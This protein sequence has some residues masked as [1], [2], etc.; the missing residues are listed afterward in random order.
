MKLRLLFASTVI[1]CCT[2]WL[3]AEEK[4]SESVIEAMPASNKT[5]ARARAMMLHEMVRGT[6][7]IMHRDFFD[8]DNAHAIPSASL[9][10]VFHEMGKSY[11]MQLKWLI[12]NTDVI[13]IDHQAETSFEKAAVKT[14]AAG[15][16]FAEETSANRYQF[17]GPIR[18]SSQC[19]KCHVK[20]RTS[21]D[22]RTAG[23]VITMPIAPEPNPQR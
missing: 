10:D 9:E 16:P 8:E 4:Q 17:A 19:L 23:L 15:K 2:A 6:L 3:F 14:L 18:L 22:D 21:N 1:F 12:V 20:R 5:E 7:Q 11:N 13:N